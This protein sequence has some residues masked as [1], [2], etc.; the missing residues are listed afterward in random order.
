MTSKLVNGFAKMDVDTMEVIVAA[1]VGSVAVAAMLGIGCILIMKMMWAKQKRINEALGKEWMHIVAENADNQQSLNTLRSSI[2]STWTSDFALTKSSKSTEHA[3]AYKTRDDCAHSF[4]CINADLPRTFANNPLFNEMKLNGNL[5]WVLHGVAERYAN[6]YLSGMHEIAALILLLLPPA[7]AELLLLLLLNNRRYS[8]GPVMANVTDVVAHFSSLLEH[9][10]PHLKVHL[11][12]LEVSPMHYVDW[13]STVFVHIAPTEEA[14]VIFD[15]FIREGWVA[16]Y[17]CALYILSLLEARLMETNS[18]S[19]CLTLIRSFCS[20]P[21]TK[22]HG[23]ISGTARKSLAKF[24][25]LTESECDWATA[26]KLSQ[27]S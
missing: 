9:H 5:R 23:W 26:S 24:P 8:L 1:A 7:D 16:V 11:D 18:F 21:S 15:A 27:L 6:G 14:I 12:V 3:V 17:R 2:R 13:F 4:I 20:N 19:K 22:R 25:A 10:L